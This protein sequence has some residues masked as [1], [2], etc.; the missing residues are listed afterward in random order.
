MN[1]KG[2]YD[3]KRKY[4]ELPG[5]IGQEYSLYSAEVKKQKVTIDNREHSDYKWLKFEDAVKRLTFRN[6]KKCLGV[7]NE[8]L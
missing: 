8:K 2:K 3:Y 5:F 1:I 6:Q 7:V 4:P